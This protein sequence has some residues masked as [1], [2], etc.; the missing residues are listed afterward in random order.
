MSA[1][2]HDE[3]NQAF[4]WGMEDKW[5]IRFNPTCWVKFGDDTSEIKWFEKYVA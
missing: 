3:D 5:R 1:V 2:G 4:L